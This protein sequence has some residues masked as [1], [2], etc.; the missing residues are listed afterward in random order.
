MLIQNNKEDI[1]YYGIGIKYIKIN[2]FHI[3]LDC[4]FS[5][6]NNEIELLKGFI[7][8]I[9]TYDPDII[10]GY[11]IQMQSLGFIIERANFLSKN[12]NNFNKIILLEINLCSEISRVNDNFDHFQN[13]KD[14]W[15]YRHNSGKIK[16]FNN[17]IL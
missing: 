3:K 12:I 7:Q 16:N 15:N 2:F 9:R 10:I 6:F 14:N 4:E 11:E 5:F 17:N 8:L 13:E 1:S